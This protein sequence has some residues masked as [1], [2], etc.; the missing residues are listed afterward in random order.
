M[1]Q[2]IAARLV[3]AY[4]HAASVEEPKSGNLLAPFLGNFRI[5]LIP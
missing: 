4:S 5:G 1:Q 3:D 2:V